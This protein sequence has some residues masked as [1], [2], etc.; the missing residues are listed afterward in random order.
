MRILLKYVFQE[1][2][3]AKA[4]P[5][6]NA[7][8]SLNRLSHPY[9]SSVF[10][11]YSSNRAVFCTPSAF[12]WWVLSWGIVLPDADAK[13]KDCPT[14]PENTNGQSASTTERQNFLYKIKGFFGIFS[15]GAASPVRTAVQPIAITHP[16]PVWTSPQLFTA[17][18]SDRTKY[19]RARASRDSL[20]FVVL[21]E[22]TPS[23]WPSFPVP[24]ARHTVQNSRCYI[25]L[26]MGIRVTAACSF[27]NTA[28][29]SP[30]VP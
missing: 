5:S 16:W 6:A 2:R 1:R 4:D 22:I 27:A 8:I 3:T 15:A 30:C 20:P 11:L 12:R 18:F 29:F 14:V 19:R 25:R 24:Y 9:A 7:I 21:G 23:D 10:R 13:I 17:G 28:P 26:P